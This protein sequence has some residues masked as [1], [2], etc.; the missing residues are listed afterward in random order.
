MDLNQE[1]V[2]QLGA[3]LVDIFE[4][5]DR[6]RPPFSEH[7]GI[8]TP[9]TR[10]LDSNREKALFLT[11]TTALNRQRDAKQLYSKFERLWYDDHWIFEPE[12]L[13]LER[14]FEELATLFHNEGVRF[15]EKDAEVWYEIART[16][17]HD[18]E[19]NPMVLL[20]EFNYNMECLES[21]IRTASGETRFFANGKKFPS[22]RGD[23]I[24]P[25]WLRLISNQVHPLGS[26]DGSDVSVDIHIIQITNRLLET[27]YTTDEADK[28][29]I[30]KFWRSVCQAKPIKPIDID[31]P[32]WYIN[33]GWEEWGRAYLV[34]Q[35][36][37]R[38]GTIGKLAGGGSETPPQTDTPT[39][40]R[41]D[42]ERYIILQ[43]EFHEDVKDFVDSSPLY[44]DVEEFVNNAIS[45]ELKRTT[46]S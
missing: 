23:K 26:E 9:I 34:D 24:R 12:T 31:G 39:Q 10:S 8:T 37:K 33:R 29:E 22:L 18:Y 20:E 27:E 5:Y 44:H 42:N 46:D 25:L 13:V 4:D 43:P 36:K 17:Y 11:F 35:L 45:N 40:D 19:S 2:D 7:G 32:L 1:E 15:G 28:S 6:W 38:G 21:H 30:R 41:S 16:L 3:A 14:D